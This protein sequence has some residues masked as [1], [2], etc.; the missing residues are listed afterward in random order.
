LKKVFYFSFRCKKKRKKERKGRGLTEERKNSSATDS[1]WIRLR[2]STRLDI[3][4][5]HFEKSTVMANQCSEADS[6][7]LIIELDHESSLSA[8]LDAASYYL[9]K[10]IKDSTKQQVLKKKKKNC[11]KS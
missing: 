3:T 9:S 11:C 1:L 6:S 4:T 5:Q 10:S 8:G 7:S 2:R